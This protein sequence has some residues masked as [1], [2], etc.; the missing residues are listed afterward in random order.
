MASHPSGR[1]L[2]S[3]SPRPP[4]RRTGAW[5]KR[6]MRLR[7]RRR[8]REG[9]RST[10]R[11]EE[12]VARRWEGK[13]AAK[14]V[15][16]KR[17]GGSPADEV[18]VAGWLWCCEGSSRC[19]R[20]DS[21]DSM[22]ERQRVS[23]AFPR[24]TRI[25][26]HRRKRMRVGELRA[27]R[28]RWPP[29]RS[30]QAAREGEH[31]PSGPTSSRELAACHSVD[32]DLTD[33]SRSCRLRCP[34][35]GLPACPPRRPPLVCS[36]PRSLARSKTSKGVIPGKEEK[37]DTTKLHACSA[38]KLTVSMQGIPSAKDSV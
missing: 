5:T 28:I 9:Q 11:G 20:R 19:S 37:I 8:E 2:R 10:S 7:L 33:V 23:R 18:A 26:L 35:F 29:S 16:S 1:C 24:A 15:R 30:A 36:S 14:E 32:A 34:V 25:D 13:G 27:E 12:V 17:R 3:V 31:E 38:R 6:R 22:C 21:Y 4:A